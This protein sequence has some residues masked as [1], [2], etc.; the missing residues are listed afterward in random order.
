MNPGGKIRIAI[1]IV[2]MVVLASFTTMSL[3]GI[4]QLDIETAAVNIDD[5]ADISVD[6]SDFTPIAK[7]FSL[8]LN[9]FVYVITAETYVLLILILSLILLTPFMLIGLN[10]KRTIE[11]TEYKIVKYAFII[12]LILSFLAGGILT[13]FSLF[14]ATVFMN[15]IWA[16]NVLIFCIIPLKMRNANSHLRKS[17]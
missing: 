1:S 5:V 8:G 12:I 3:C 14:I 6:G 10:P 11:K 15:A 4:Y 17:E 2:I 16:L 7:L 9:T 13:R